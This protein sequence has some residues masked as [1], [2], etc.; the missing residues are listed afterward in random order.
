MLDRVLGHV[1]GILR[2]ELLDDLLHRLAADVLHH[3]EDPTR[4]VAPDVVHRDDRRMLELADDSHLVGEAQQR[5][6]RLHLGVKA[7]HRDG[8]PDVVVARQLHVPHRAFT[9]DPDSLEAR[10]L[11]HL[12]RS[13]SGGAPRQHG[14]VPP[15]ERLRGLHVARRVGVGEERFPELDLRRRTRFEPRERRCR[16]ERQ[17]SRTVRNTMQE[18]RL[19]RRS[20]SGHEHS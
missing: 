19:E 10:A 11:L 17:P 5:L 16:G 9:Q 15:A 20:R 6:L 13:G 14:G 3:Q 12:R 18:R 7:L 2:A 1:G 4:F 8:P